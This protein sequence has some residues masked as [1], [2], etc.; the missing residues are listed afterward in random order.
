M[1]FIE[2]F[3]PYISYIVVALIILLLLKILKFKLKTLIKIAINILIGGI[4][5]YFINYIPGINITIDIWRSLAVGVFGVPAVVII[6]IIYFIYE[7]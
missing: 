1:E 4:V 3:L 2:P 6:L 5:L 7:R